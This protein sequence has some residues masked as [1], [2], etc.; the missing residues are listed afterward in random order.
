MA[1]KINYKN[2]HI[3]LI[4]VVH[5]IQAKGHIKWHIQKMRK[6]GFGE[7]ALSMLDRY[8]K[9]MREELLRS[10]NKEAPDLV[11]EEG[12]IYDEVPGDRWKTAIRSGKTILEELYSDKHLFVDAK[13]PK[14]LPRLRKPSVRKR[15]EAFVQRLETHLSKANTIKNIVF[16]IGID[17]LE[18]VSDRLKKRGFKVEVRNLI[19]ELYPE[20]L[21]QK[22]KKETKRL[23]E[24]RL[25]VKKKLFWK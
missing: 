1:K 2:T 18:R 3:L 13:A 15:E 25:R 24:V 7:D 23:K 9:S 6:K 22:V 12:G 11:V 16:I 21:K 20:E 17:H 19:K 14:F 5:E 8:L 4:G 10:C